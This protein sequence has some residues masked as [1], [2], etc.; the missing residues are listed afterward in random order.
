MILGKIIFS[1]YFRSQTH[2]SDPKSRLYETKKWSDVKKRSIIRRRLASSTLLQILSTIGT[3]WVLPEQPWHPK[4]FLA[5]FRSQTGSTRSTRALYR[6]TK[7]RSGS[8][9]DKKIGS[10]ESRDNFLPNKLLSIPNGQ[11]VV[12]IGV[13][14]SGP[15]K[16]LWAVPLLSVLAL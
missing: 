1:T 3:F 2:I 7:R 14:E 9:I 11:I 12:E 16:K 10:R 6:S 5:R 13:L 8:E 15:R 4:R